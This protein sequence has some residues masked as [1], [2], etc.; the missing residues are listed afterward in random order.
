M[1]ICRPARSPPWRTSD[2]RRL[3]PLPLRRYRGEYPPP[4]RDGPHRWVL[5]TCG[6]P[7]ARLDPTTQAGALLRLGPLASPPGL[8]LVGVPCERLHLDGD[9]AVRDIECLRSALPWLSVALHLPDALPGA[10]RAA[11]QA[12]LARHGAIVLPREPVSLSELPALFAGT[13]EPR[14]HIP[15]WLEFA[16]PRWDGAQRSAAVDLLVSG[17]AYDPEVEHALRGHIPRNQQ[18]WT[19]VGRALRAAVR[20]QRLPSESDEAVALASGFA[21]RKAMERSLRRLFGTPP[22]MIRGTAGWEWLMWR[23]LCGAGTGRA[24]GWDQIRGRGARLARDAPRAAAQNA[25]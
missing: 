1:E 5:R 15:P 22:R 2:E 24:K 7:Y 13:F 4:L 3:L 17:F 9:G 16:V 18:V 25:S 21:D 19:R 8:I 10:T 12:R 23:F 14:L 20:A 11:V 6:P